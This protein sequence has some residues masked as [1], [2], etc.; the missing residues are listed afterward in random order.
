MLAQIAT[1]PI[2][3]TGILCIFLS[4]GKSTKP[5]FFEKAITNGTMNTPNIYEMIAPIMFDSGNL[6]VLSSLF[7]KWEFFAQCS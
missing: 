7:V 2:R 4:F 6:I 5:S 3:E 1:P